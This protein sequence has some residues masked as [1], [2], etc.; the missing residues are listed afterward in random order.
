MLIE[1]QPTLVKNKTKT[2]KQKTKQ[3]K[4]THPICGFSFRV[5]ITLMTVVCAVVC[6][7]IERSKNN[8]ILKSSPLFQDSWI[9]KSTCVKIPNSHFSS[10]PN[11]HML[12]NSYN[13][14]T[15]K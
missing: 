5:V 8:L 11:L 3:K 14:D 7:I 4:P 13:P 15:G 2:N 10:I 1:N 6:D 12:V 9:N